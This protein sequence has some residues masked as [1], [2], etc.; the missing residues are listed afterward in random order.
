MA[1]KIYTQDELTTWTVD[2]LRDYCKTLGIPKMSKQRKDVLISTILDCQKSNNSGETIKLAPTGSDS[3]ARDSRPI[4]NMVAVMNMQAINPA[5]SSSKM[6]TT[7]HVSCGA[8]SGN[9]SVV[10]KTVAEVASKLKDVLNIDRLSIGVVN[11]KDVNDSY[12]VKDGDNL[13]FVKPAG[14]K[15]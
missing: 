2:N 9:F 6:N 5:S 15:G 11:G 12:I 1:S 7:I 4:T 3:S 13:E 8:S 10:G 14:T